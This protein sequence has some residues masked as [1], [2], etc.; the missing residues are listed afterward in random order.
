MTLDLDLYR[1]AG[2]LCAASEPHRAADEEW[3]CESCL[4]RV[5]TAAA[6]PSS[7]RSAHLLAEGRAGVAGNALLPQPGAPVAP[8]SRAKGGSA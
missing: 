8:T 5:S 2:A 1:R 6:R 7:A 3:P 4:K